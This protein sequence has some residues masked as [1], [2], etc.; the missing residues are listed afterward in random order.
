MAKRTI[1]LAGKAG[2]ATSMAAGIVDPISLSLMLIP[3]LGGQRGTITRSQDPVAVVG[4][5]VAAGEAQQYALT[6]LKETTAYTDNILPRLGANALLA[7][8]LGAWATRMPKAEFSELASKADAAINPQPKDTTTFYHSSPAEFTQFDHTKIGTGEGN[9]SF[10]HG[11][12][13]AENPEIVESYSTIAENK[14]AES[15]LYKF[16]VKNKDLSEM[17]DWDKPLREQPAILKALDVDP[18]VPA[19]LNGIDP[20]W[21]G[22]ELHDNLLKGQDTN[23]RST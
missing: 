21:S 5:N 22:Q 6:R 2:W 4:T 9:Q 19:K 8:V 3:G 17:L 14:G 12:Y 13:S 10:S 16:E 15:N 18:N 7:G 11:I 20:A 1:A 23:L